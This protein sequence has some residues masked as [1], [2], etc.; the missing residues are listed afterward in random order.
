MSKKQK[1]E[2]AV[3]EPVAVAP[4][5]QENK[6]PK[7]E[8]KDRVY[9][10]RSNKT[11][12]V[13]I[14]KSRGLLWF[15]EKLGY[16]RE[17]KY[18]ENQK[19]VFLDEMKGPERLSHIIFRDGQLYVS[20]EKQ[21]LQKFLSLYHPENGKTFIEYNAVQIAEN[22]I[23][24]LESEIEALTAAQKIEIDHAEAILRTELGDKVS[25]MTSKE[26]KRDLLLFARANPQLFLELANDENI[27]IRNLG[28]KAVEAGI[29]KLSNDN[30][31]FMWGTNDRKLM[32]VPFD[33][34]PYSALAAYFKTDEGVEVYQTVE[35]KLK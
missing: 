4:P 21:T 31:T 8:I 19:T 29:I 9:E 28:I 7:W 20:K 15:D 6:T 26:L 3:E 34:N 10:L 1:A 11:P 18:C 25:A 13:Y 35:K 24:Y 14:L 23:S 12:I 5:K 30:R 32:T 33:E 27:N 17:I 22:D 2:V 16:E